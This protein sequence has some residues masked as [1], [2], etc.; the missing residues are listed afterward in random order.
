M[1]DIG[2]VVRG[3]DRPHPDRNGHIPDNGE[4]VGLLEERNCTGTRASTMLSAAG[5]FEVQ[6]ALDTANALFELADQ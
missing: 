1:T 3:A 6:V 4:L 2:I 5:G